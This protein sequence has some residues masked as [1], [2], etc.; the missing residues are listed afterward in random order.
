MDRKYRIHTLIRNSVISEGCVVYFHFLNNDRVAALLMNI[1]GNY[2]LHSL[3]ALWKP[4]RITRGCWEN[5]T[6]AAR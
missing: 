5:R 2:L 1:C 6:R 3:I 4:P